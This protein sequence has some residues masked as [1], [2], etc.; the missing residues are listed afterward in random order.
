MTVRATCL[1]FVLATGCTALTH[2]DD[3]DVTASAPDDRIC[4]LCPDRPELA[5]PPCASGVPAPEGEGVY[6]FA[7]RALDLGTRASGWSEGYQVGLDQDCSDRPDG[8]PVACT[9]RTPDSVFETLADGIDNT[10]AT[11]V[12][13][14][15][16]QQEGV[17]PQTLMNQSLEA[18]AGGVLLVIDR[19]NGT[20]NDDDVGVRLVPSLAVTNADGRGSPSWAG[21]DVW[22]VIADRWDPMFPDANVPDTQN[23]GGTAYVAD[24][25]LVWDARE[26]PDFLLP[27]GAGGALVDVRLAGV[28]FTGRLI[29]D[30]NP[31]LLLDGV[32]SGVWSAFLASRNAGRL[33]EI[34]SQCDLCAA[35]AI[36]PFI[37][38][39]VHDAPDM[40]LPSSGGASSC[41]AISVGFLGSYVESANAGQILPMSAIPQSCAGA[42]PCAG[43]DD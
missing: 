38:D 11:E 1:L 18:G 15:L 4:A 3:Y 13:H 26:I 27:F 43:R 28:V 14:P 5:H 17:N 42:E 6:Y 34:V 21:D 32:L 36:T 35:E 16:I 19:W 12:L 20:A 33:A 22:A 7:L 37:E 30:Q 9:P 23:K 40:L 25:V 41:D 2:A 8:K 10:L 24:G 29:T 31:K 39:L